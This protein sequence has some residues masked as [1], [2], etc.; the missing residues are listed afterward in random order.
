[1]TKHKQSKSVARE[2]RA[3]ETNTESVRVRAARAS[4][5]Q[6]KDALAAVPGTPPMS[7]D[8][9][10]VRYEIDPANPPKLT[11]K[12]RDEIA[13]LRKKRDASIDF[14]DLPKLAEE[15]SA[16]FA[17]INWQKKLPNVS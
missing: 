6:F 3:T 13:A 7:G 4:A 8:E 2:T 5:E 14:S 15:R 16:K 10:L 17:R 1:M 12:Q 9:K 11:A